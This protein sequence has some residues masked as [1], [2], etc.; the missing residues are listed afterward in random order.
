[1]M[2]SASSALLSRL[3]PFWKPRALVA[4]GESPETPLQVHAVPGLITLL[5]VALFQ[6]VEG[7]LTATICASHALLAAWLDV[8]CQALQ[9]LHELSQEADLVGT[10]TYSQ[11]D[12]FARTCLEGACDAIERMST[13]RLASTANLS[14]PYDHLSPDSNNNNNNSYHHHHSHHYHHAYSGGGISGDSNAVISATLQDASRETSRRAPQQQRHSCWESSRLHCLDFCWAD[15][16]QCHSQRLLRQLYRHH[17]CTHQHHNSSR[18]GKASGGGGGGGGGGSSKT[19][20]SA[21][22]AIAEGMDQQS[23]LAPGTQ[24]EATLL[25]QL[26]QSDVPTRLVQFQSAISAD[27]IVSK[28]LYLTK[29]VYRAPFRAFLEAHQSVQRAPSLELVDEFLLAASSSSSR[30][31][32]KQQ[33]TP[34]ASAKKR[35]QE[36]LKTKELVEAV[37]LEQNCQEMEVELAKALFPF[38]ELARYL[39]HKRARLQHAPGT[40][41]L[42]QT[43]IIA[44]ND[45]DDGDDDPDNAAADRDVMDALVELQE[46]LRRLKGL[47]CNRKVSTA[48]TTTPLEARRTTTGIRPLLLDLQGVPRDEEEATERNHGMVMR[49]WLRQQQH[50]S[51]HYKSNSNSSNSKIPVS[52]KQREKVLERN[53]QMFLEKLQTLAKLCTTKNAFKVENNKNHK[54]TELDIP[55]TIVRGCTKQFDAELFRCRVLDW[56]TFVQRQHEIL[57]QVEQQQHKEQQQQEQRGDPKMMTPDT[58]L[59]F[60]ELAENIRQA[61]I[62]MSLAGATP[63]SLEVVRQRLDLIHTDREKRFQVLKEIVEEVCLREMNLFVS[64]CNP[65]KTDA[66]DLRATPSA[67]GIFG[68]AL[69][70]AGEILPL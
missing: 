57:E 69:Q 10:T 48:A 45:D 28:R 62:Q 13:D 65:S 52:K 18:G 12:S 36:L 51:H 17:F 46:T 70:A 32:Q 44:V 24:R 68:R 2:A 6:S 61:E 54:N 33:Q 64:V 66:L 7:E 8:K 4:A 11:L 25:L 60:E 35:L 20:S 23:C 59:F 31:Q 55:A 9:V 16:A 15:D 42:E 39:E 49:W 1:M 27:S 21:V 19:A 47:L 38:C 30:Q 53:L 5:D 41:I 26:V 56:H 3:I 58:E 43:A 34:A 63:Q 67:L 50:R 29:C 22:D 37:A 40:I 14:D